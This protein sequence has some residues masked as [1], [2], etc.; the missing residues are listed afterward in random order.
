[1]HQKFTLVSTIVRIM[2]AM[3]TLDYLC[4]VTSRFLHCNN[5]L[6][7]DF[8]PTFLP[9]FQPFA[10]SVHYP[11]TFPVIQP[12]FMIETY[13]NILL[14]INFHFHTSEYDP[15]YVFEGYH[16]RF[17]R[18]YHTNAMQSLSYGYIGFFREEDEQLT[19]KH[20]SY[21]NNEFT[22]HLSIKLGAIVM[23]CVIWKLRVGNIHIRYLHY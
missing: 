12:P 4:Y 7:P 18:T 23:D 20:V 8:L 16:I 17:I 1:M 9:R 19:L 5:E 21:T 22:N 13:K 15:L 2:F 6:L 11:S 3:P 10:N 14:T